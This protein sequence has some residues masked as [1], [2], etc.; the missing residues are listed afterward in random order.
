MSTRKDSGSTISA[1]L[2][3]SRDRFLRI[4]DDA[5]AVMVN[6]ELSSE[7]IEVGLG[8]AG[9]ERHESPGQGRIGA[10][11]SFVDEF[12][13]ARQTRDIEPAHGYGDSSRD[14]SGRRAS[15]CL[16][17]ARFPSLVFAVGPAKSKHERF[18]ID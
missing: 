18:E 13:I 3:V 16:V 7:R 14:V 5:L 10:S 11:K 2:D 12:V 8:R 17:H 4:G 15:S 9:A 1:F 6:E